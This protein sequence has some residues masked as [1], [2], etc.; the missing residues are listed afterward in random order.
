MQAAAPEAVDLRTETETIK[1]MYGLND[2][3]TE[4]FG[5]KLPAGPAIGGARRSIRAAL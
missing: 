4:P 2:K 3:A 5:A 1:S